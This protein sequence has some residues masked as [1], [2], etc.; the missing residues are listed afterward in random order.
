MSP[1][2][3]PERPRHVRDF[4]LTGWEPSATGPFPEP[5]VAG[6]HQP[7]VVGDRLY[8]GY[9]SA[10]HGVLQPSR[11]TAS[12]FDLT[13]AACPSSRDAAAQTAT[14]FAGL[15]PVGLHTAARQD[16]TSAL[17]EWASHPYHHPFGVKEVEDSQ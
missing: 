4:A 1:I 16:L 3:N 2:G 12:R 8:L 15:W 7:L 10:E 13:V 11:F 9:G 14:L 6:L 5:S 17:G